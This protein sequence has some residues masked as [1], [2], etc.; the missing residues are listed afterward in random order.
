M[1][2]S[3]WPAHF[4]PEESVPGTS[5]PFSFPTGRRRP[6]PSGRPRI[7]G[8]IVT[9]IVHFYGA[10][11]V[12]YILRRTRVRALVTT[13]HFGRNDYLAV[14]DSVR[15]QAPDLEHVIV[16]S[17][18]PGAVVG[19]TLCR[20][21]RRGPRH[22]AGR[23]RSRCSSACRLHLG[24]DRRPERRRALTSHDLLRDRA[25][26]VHADRQS[27][28]HRGCTCRSWHW[29]AEWVAPSCPQARADQPDRCLGSGCGAGMR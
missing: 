19:R 6:C 23:S 15:S 11:E 26:R 18:R 16:L 27:S 20:C 29:H 4:G 17:D 1:R 2:P 28:T 14:L 12:D 7:L 25:A 5:W 13:D 24:H 21:P 9:P 22:R 3:T 8:A 10:K